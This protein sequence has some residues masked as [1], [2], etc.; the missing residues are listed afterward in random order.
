M[1]DAEEVR[2]IQAGLKVGDQFSSRGEVVPER[3]FDD[4][5]GGKSGAN[6]AGFCELFDDGR[7]VV[8][9]GG[10]IENVLGEATGFGQLFERFFEFQVGFGVVEISRMV[11]KFGGEVFP[12]LSRDGAQTGKL[13]QAFLHFFAE[14]VIC[15]GASGKADDRVVGGESAF[16]LQ[17]EEGG[18]EFAVG[19]ISAGAEDHHHKRGENPIGFGGWT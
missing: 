8:R 18:N 7:K 2:F 3:F 13:I 17:A 6:E 10:E 4:N 14:F 19:E 12:V 16:V 1:I 9:S 5:A 11:R 15:F